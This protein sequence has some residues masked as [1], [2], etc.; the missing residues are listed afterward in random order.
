MSW[1]FLRVGQSGSATVS[2][3]EALIAGLGS[4][5]RE[6]PELSAY[7]YLRWVERAEREL[8]SRFVDPSVWRVLHTERYWR[9]RSITSSTIRP[10]TMI[11]SE[12]ADQRLVLEAIADQLRHYEKMLTP[13]PDE[14]LLLL[15]TNVLVHGLLFGQVAWNELTAERKVRLIMPLIVI[16]ELDNLKNR[17]ESK[18]ASALRELDRHLVP[19]HGLSNTAL[20][21]NVTLQ[22]VDE[23]VGHHRLANAD[24]EIVHQAGYFASL[25]ENR[26]TLIT[27]DRGMRVRAEAA[28]IEVLML[29]T[30]LRRSTKEG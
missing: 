13:G 27:S 7:N 2:A 10:L 3:I 9:I 11:Q 19:G 22:I 8:R 5:D 23:P 14:R 1:R 6:D 28:S 24:D 25:S 15:D 20:R 29:P 26:I 17:S 4:V 12:S 30:R 18:A 21:T 16:D